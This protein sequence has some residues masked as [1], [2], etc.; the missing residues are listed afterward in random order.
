[1]ASAP[2]EINA[3]LHMECKNLCIYLLASISAKENAIISG[4]TV[5]VCMEQDANLVIAKF[6]GKHKHIS[7][8]SVA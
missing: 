5:A 7:M 8:E 2:T 3:G 6:N 4:K 1:M